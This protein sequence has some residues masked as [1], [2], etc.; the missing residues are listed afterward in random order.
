MY[1]PNRS[2]DSH[3]T[4]TGHKRDN[5]GG[6][7]NA[8]QR[9]APARVV[10]QTERDTKLIN[11]N[12]V[13]DELGIKPVIHAAGTITSF[14]GSMPRPEVL[15]A[16]VLA[17]RSFA[18]LEEVNDKVGAYIAKITGSEAGMVVSGAAGGIVLSMAACMTG[19]NPASVRQLPDTTGMKNELAIQKIHRGGYSHMY[20]FTGARFAE[21]G[22]VNGCLP[23]E[24]EAVINKNTAAVAYLLG[25]GVLTNGLSLSEV[26]EIAHTHELPVIVDAAAMLPPR[27]NL[28]RFI[29]DGADLVTMSGGKYIRGPQGTGLLFGRR[30]LIEA[31]RANGAPSH[32]IG[33][34]QKVTKEEMV[35]LYTAMT[36]FMEQ[37]DEALFVQYRDMITPIYE[38]LKGI[39]NLDVS[40]RLNATQ[41]HVPTLVLGLRSDE[42][43][44]DSKKLLKELLGGEPRVFMTYD[45]TSDALSVNPI[46][47]MEGEQH[48]LADRL[49]ELL[50]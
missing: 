47:L 42:T 36:L 7:P 46:N 50:R 33:R 48:P 37:D 41:Y 49:L 34:P 12:P 25:P 38:K 3:T 5:G 22:S 6:G 44:R 29:S 35:G 10:S 16:M 18:G 28:R 39:K 43:G 13:Y 2:G 4:V 15:E 19:T 21:A 40:I 31:A 1:N 23:E 26:A 45:A 27:S 17:A 20:T 9:S 14:G 8:G 30:D 32:S 24:L 11:S